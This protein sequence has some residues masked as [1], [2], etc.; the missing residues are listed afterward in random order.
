VEAE[1]AAVEA[2]E[3]AVEAEKAASEALEEELWRGWSVRA[4]AE[5]LEAKRLAALWR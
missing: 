5:R 2:E 4:A 3:A 1:E